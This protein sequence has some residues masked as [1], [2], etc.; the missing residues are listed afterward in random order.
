VWEEAS[1]FGYYVIGDDPAYGSSDEADSSALSGWRCYAD[2][3]VQV[4]EFC[5]PEPS[6]YQNAWVLAHLAG[7]YGMT[8]V[9]PVLEITGPGQAVFDELQKLQKLSAEIRPQEDTHGIR[10]LLG[11]MRHFFYR[12]IDTPGGGG[13]VFH[14]KTTAELKARMMHQFKNGV[15]L[16]RV[17][18][19]SVPLIEE[20]RR[21]VND[22]GYIGGEGRAKDDRVMAAAMAYQGYNMFA[23]PLLKA[24]GLTRARAAEIDERGGTEPVDRLI[25]NF[26]RKQ[27]IKVPA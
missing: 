25:V 8:W 13:L 16:G 7:Y 5:S 10:N 4:A 1:K 23:Q 19:R 9:Q 6:T 21:I 17:I 12:R 2:C 11:N 20:M 22:E 24:M 14:W 18:P 3:M 15:E 26:L 27:N